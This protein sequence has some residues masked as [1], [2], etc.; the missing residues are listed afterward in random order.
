LNFFIFFF[1]PHRYFSIFLYYF[2]IITNPRSQTQ[3]IKFS[4][5]ARP[6]TFKIK[7][8]I[9]FRQYSNERIATC[10]S[11]AKG[12]RKS[13]TWRATCRARGAR[14]KQVQALEEWA[15]RKIRRFLSCFSYD[16]HL[17]TCLVLENWTMNWKI[18]K[19]SLL[20]NFLQTK[21]Y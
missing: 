7:L 18:T 9:Y 4:S 17:V 8:Y 2:D 5:V 11:C 15:N 13:S 14:L 6:K 21:T 20:L 1:T 10:P 3:A 12:Q 16:V 19:L